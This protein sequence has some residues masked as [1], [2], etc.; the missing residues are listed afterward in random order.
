MPRPNRA[1]PIGRPMAMTEPNAM[2]QDDH[3]G[4]QAEAFGADRPALRSAATSPPNSTWR[5]ASLAAAV[6]TGALRTPR[7]RA[8]VPT[9]RTGRCRGAMVP[10]SRHHTGGAGCGGGD[11]IDGADDVGQRRRS[12][13]RWRRWP[14]R[15][16]GRRAGRRG[17]GRRPGPGRRP[18]RG[19]CPRARRAL[20]AIRRRGSRTRRGARRRRCGRTAEHDHGKDPGD[21]DEPAAPYGESPESVEGGGHLELLVARVAAHI[22]APSAK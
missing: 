7:D 1:V 19:R 13:R 11:G 22:L 20:A 3:G 6:A 15:W 12:P 18:A 21:Q 4:E 8:R 16:P 17:C 14:R 5:P 2:Q 10:S 9:R